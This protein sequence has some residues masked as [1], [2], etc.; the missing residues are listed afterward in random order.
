MD[1][2]MVTRWDWDGLKYIA[3]PCGHILDWR[4]VKVPDDCPAC[5]YMKKEAKALIEAF[6]HDPYMQEVCR[7]YQSWLENQH[8]ELQEAWKL[9]NTPWLFRNL[10]ERN[11]K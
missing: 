3:Q 11:R 7:R 9:R 10:I 8:P 4:N 1:D 6:D 2:N 5:A